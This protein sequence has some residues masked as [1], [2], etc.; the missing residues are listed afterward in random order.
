MF[1]IS[2]GVAF[3]YGLVILILAIRNA[4]EGVEDAEGFHPI[5]PTTS[6]PED[7]SRGVEKPK[8]ARKNREVIPVSPEGEPHLNPG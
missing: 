5:K 6:M 1:L 4:P 3:V 2:L 7:L 8:T